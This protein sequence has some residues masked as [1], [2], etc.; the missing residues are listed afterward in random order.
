LL[1]GANCVE[2]D[3]SGRPVG[4]FDDREAKS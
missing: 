3:G 4:A 2:F 1:G